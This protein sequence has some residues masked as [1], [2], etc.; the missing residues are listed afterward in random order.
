MQ[1]AGDE[2]G[3]TQQSNNNAYCQDIEI[4]W[5]SWQLIDADRE[6]L[7][8]THR[9]IALRKEHQVFRKRS[10][11]QGQS[12]KGSEVKAITWFKPDGNEMSDE[13]WP[14]AYA[15]SLGMYLAGRA[16]GARDQFGRPVEDDDILLLLNDHHE[17][18]P[19]T[20]PG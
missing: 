19:F 1:L 5:L 4:S 12:I 15:R 18:V 11:F 13:E 7:Y 9:L 17:E 14:H 10:F 20:L 6:L 2:M 3:R 16:V 8:F